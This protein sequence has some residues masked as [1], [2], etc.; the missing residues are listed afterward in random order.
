MLTTVVQLSPGSSTAGQHCPG[1]NTF[2]SCP[3]GQ[4]LYS[5][6]HCPLQN[7]LL[8]SWKGRGELQRKAACTPQRTH[9]ALHGYLLYKAGNVWHLPLQTDSKKSPAVYLPGQALPD[10]CLG[11]S[12][13][14]CFYTTNLHLRSSQSIWDS[15]GSGSCLLW[16]YRVPRC[17]SAPTAANPGN[18]SS[19][20]GSILSFHLFQPGLLFQLPAPQND[21]FSSL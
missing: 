7:Q 14:M 13:K 4:V 8:L 15:L 1:S 3:Q 21:S 18:V 20:H 12:L 5:Q 10:F 19:S 16:S 17:C 9:S 2:V 6:L 11:E